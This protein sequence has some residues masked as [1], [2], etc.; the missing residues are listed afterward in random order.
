MGDGCLGDIDF[1]NITDRYQQPAEHTRVEPGAVGKAHFD[2]K[3]SG[4]GIRRRDDFIHN[5]LIFFVYGIDFDHK[6]LAFF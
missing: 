4:T 5:G 6:V 1:F 3:R 2:Q